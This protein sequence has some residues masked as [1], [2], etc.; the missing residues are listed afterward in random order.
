MRNFT[1]VIIRNEHLPKIEE[2]PHFGRQL[3]SAIRSLKDEPEQTLDV[4]ANGYDQSTPD[5]ATVI[6]QFDSE[7]TKMI[8]FTGDS[9]RLLP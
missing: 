3:A 7:D 1:T 2:D 9:A 8:V 6:C 4:P 5:A